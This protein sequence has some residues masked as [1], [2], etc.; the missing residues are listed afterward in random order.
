MLY[1]YFVFEW[2]SRSLQTHAEK[3]HL[4]PEGFSVRL[5]R[6]FEKIVDHS[7]MSAFEASMNVQKSFFCVFYCLFVEII[8]C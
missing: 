5:P 4:W 7:N 1:R 8:A 6:S 3:R 2:V